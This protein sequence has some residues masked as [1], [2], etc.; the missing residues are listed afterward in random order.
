ML[1]AEIIGTIQSFKYLLKFST[2]SSQTIKSKPINS[3]NFILQVTTTF[4]QSFS[5][6][7]HSIS[8]TNPA[9]SAN[10]P[11]LKAFIRVLSEIFTNHKDLILLGK[12]N[13][14]F[15]CIFFSFFCFNI[16]FNAILKELFIS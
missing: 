10:K 9:G 7:T 13:L 15:N 1:F 14:F 2:L 11:F 3:S 8:K 6:S 12:I 5:F 4:S 16:S